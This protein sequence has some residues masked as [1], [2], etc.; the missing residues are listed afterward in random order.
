MDNLFLSDALLLKVEKPARYI[1][2]EVNSIMKNPE[3]IDVRFGLCFPDVYEIGMSHVGLSILYDYMNRREDTWCERVFSPWVDLDEIMETEHIPLFTLESQQPIKEMDF[4]G[5]TITYE[6]AYTNVLRLLDLGQ[7]PLKS[8]DRSEDDPIVCAGG[9]CV[10]NPEPISDFIDFFYIGEG[11]VALDQII[12]TYKDHKAKGGTRLEYLE[13]I[14]SIDGIY[15]PA[16]YDVAYN[17]DGTIASF[18]PN[19]PH[20]KEQVKKM[21]VMNF[22]ESRYPL[23]PLVPYVQT[24]HDRVVLELFRGCSR[25]CRFCQAG[26]IYRPVR[27]KDVEILKSQAIEIVKNTGHDEISLISLSSSDYSQL[28]TLATHLIEAPE[29]EHVNL[30]L[31]SLRI[32]DFSIDLMSKVQDVKKS[33]LTFAPEAGSQRMRNVINKN[34]SEEDILQGSSD[35]FRGGWNRVKL[36]FMLGLPTE[37]EEDVLAI[38]KLGQDI[39]NKWF[40]MPK[41]LRKQRLQVVISTAFFIPK[42]FTPFQWMGQDTSEQFMEKASMINQAVNKKNIKYNSHDAN[43]SRIEGVLARGDRKL[44]D[45]ILNV[46]QQGAKYDAWTEHFDINKW[47]KAFEACDIDASFYNERTRSFDEILPW[48]FIDI[49]VKKSFMQEE[50][51]KAVQGETTVNCMEGCTNCGAMCFEGG[52]CYAPKTKV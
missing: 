5:F 27:E 46:Y 24:V 15:V 9:P 40:E 21:I 2:Q 1:G 38:P 18:K 11:E 4:L 19:N 35:A 20:A 42:A 51:E 10:Y 41:E 12:D 28:N 43:T 29:L 39:V 36:Y 49:G 3:A 13:K 23:K 48:D 6:M 7:V 33:S 26:M 25:G 30:S 14:A 31:P 37:T 8:A 16:F 45:V 32:D 34:I 44:N 52:I 17:E 50:Y 47:N 22:T